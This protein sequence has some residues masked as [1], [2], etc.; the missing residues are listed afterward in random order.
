MVGPLWQVGGVEAKS[1]VS[2]AGLGFGVACR[3]ELSRRRL[4]LTIG[5]QNSLCPLPR[6]SNMP[7]VHFPLPKAMGYKGPM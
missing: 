4:C 6:R 5:D 7:S 2:P 1:S 3:F